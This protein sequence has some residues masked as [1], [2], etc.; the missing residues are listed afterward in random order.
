MDMITSFRQGT[1]LKWN[2]EEAA[3]F[4]LPLITL[5][6][7]LAACGLHPATPDETEIATPKGE[8][9]IVYLEVPKGDRMSLCFT[10]HAETRVDS[11][12]LRSHMARLSV[13]NLNTVRAI[14]L[15]LTDMAVSGPTVNVAYALPD[16]IASS[17]RP[18][19]PLIGFQIPQHNGMTLER[20]W[21]SVWTNRKTWEYNKMHDLLRIKIISAEKP[22]VSECSSISTRRKLLPSSAGSTLLNCNASMATTQTDNY[23]HHHHNDNSGSSAE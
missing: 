11:A 14:D 7:A 1:N 4:A 9:H 19:H 22:S 20:A 16:E 3:I 10:F 13:T 23:D 18:P 8:P 21:F 6:V 5:L 12:I 17:Q 15:D 2:H